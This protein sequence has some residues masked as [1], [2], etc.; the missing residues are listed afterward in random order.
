[1]EIMFKSLNLEIRKDRA[2]DTEWLWPVEDTYCW[3]H[4]NKSRFRHLP[5]IIAA[6][7]KQHTLVIQAGGNAGYY[8]KQYAKIFDRVVTFEPDHRNFFCLCYNVPEQNVFKFRAC[9]GSNAESLALEMNVSHPANLGGLR[10]A[11]Q[12]MIPQIRIDALD[13]DP[14]L[15]HLDIEGYEGH[16]LLGAKETIERSHPMIVLEING[17]GD[18]YGWPEQKIKEI[19]SDWHYTEYHTFENDRVFVHKDHT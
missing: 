18:A 14:D 1:M 3:K 13:L 16:A 6:H 5:K 12:G 19:L 10:I 17:F 11:G 8:P 2:N 7:C 15:I 4:L 9:L